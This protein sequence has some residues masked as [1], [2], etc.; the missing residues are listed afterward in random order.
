MF[1]FFKKKN[2]RIFMSCCNIF[3]HGMTP[4]IHA[5]MT[6]PASCF[7]VFLVLFFEVVVFFLRPWSA[8]LLSRRDLCSSEKEIPLMASAQ[9]PSACQN[10]FKLS[11]NL[12]RCAVCTAWQ[13]PP[14]LYHEGCAFCSLGSNDMHIYVGV[15]N[16]GANLFA[17]S[18]RK[19]NFFPQSFLAA[20]GGGV[21]L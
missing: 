7:K 15:R 13:Q 3:G 1:L 6:S 10:I 19:G 8:C 18:V 17:E 12:W 11:E 21:P 2:H 5:W 14:I 16:G 4:N 20:R 9:I